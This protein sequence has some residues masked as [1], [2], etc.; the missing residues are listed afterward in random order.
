MSATPGAG[1]TAEPEGAAVVAEVY[2]E[3]GAALEVPEE[4]G[5]AALAEAPAALAERPAMP[6]T[7]WPLSGPASLLLTL[8]KALKPPRWCGVV[9]RHC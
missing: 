6:A 3:C 5:L 1:G 4:R 8:L 7:A 9:V 2:E